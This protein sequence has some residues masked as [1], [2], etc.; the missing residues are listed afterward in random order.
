[1]TANRRTAV[2][3]GILFIVGTVSGILSG[4][5]TGSILSAPDV[6]VQVSEKS[7]LLIVGVLLV[8][9]MGFALAMVPVM[10]FPL[11]KKHNQALALG[12]VLFRGALEAVAYILIV[13]SWLA[14]LTLSR[15]YVH[16]G[17]PEAISFQTLSIVLLDAGNWINQILGI[18]FSLGALMI[19]T[20]FY[21]SKLIPRWL[22][23][24]GLIGS[25]LYFAP[26]V[27]Y[28]FGIDLG[29]LVA[30]LALQEM[31]MAIWL[32]AKGFSPIENP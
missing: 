7:S 25:G 1:M 18:V 27:L 22:S 16:S 8:L 13:I 26:H 19:Y 6:L 9:T 15:E 17:T 29:F 24:W 2:I 10:L 4:V 3:V 14:L 12:A 23:I 32:I 5:V 30:P 31:V 28:L 20:V 11:F 21:Q